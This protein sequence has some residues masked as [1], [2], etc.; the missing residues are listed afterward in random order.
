MNVNIYKKNLPNIFIDV[1]YYKLLSLK[2]FIPNDYVFILLIY[3][4]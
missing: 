4:N 1:F 3:F 2:H